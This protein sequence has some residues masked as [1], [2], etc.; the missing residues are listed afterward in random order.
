[1]NEETMIGVGRDLNSGMLPLYNKNM[2]TTLGMTIIA[3]TI[4]DNYVTMNSA[5]NNN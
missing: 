4:E 5:T 2:E 3:P 1:M